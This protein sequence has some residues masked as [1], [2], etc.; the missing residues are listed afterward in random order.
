MHT[1]FKHTLSHCI[2][3]LGFL[4]LGILTSVPNGTSW[5]SNTKP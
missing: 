3:V 2:L 1:A 5:D 4:S